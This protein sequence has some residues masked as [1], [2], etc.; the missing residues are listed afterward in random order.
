MAS[1]GENRP[2]TLPTSTGTGAS[3]PVSVLEF[4]ARGDGEA[5]DTAAI[6]Y[7]LDSGAKKVI[8]PQGTYLLTNCIEPHSGQEIEIIGTLKVADAIVRTVRADVAAGQDQIGLDDTRGLYPGQWVTLADANLRLQSGGTNQTRRTWAEC[9][10]IR[11]VRG[12]SVVLDGTLSESYSLA[13]GATLATQ[14]SALLIEGASGVHVH[15]SGTIDGNKGGQFDVAPCRTGLSGEEVRAGCGI[16]VSEPA[17][18][19]VI[20][21]LTVRDAVL[22]NISLNRASFCTV[23]NTTCTGAH[24]KNILLLYCFDCRIVGNTTRD[25]D[26]ED[27]IILYTGSHRCLVQQNICTGNPR[28]GIHVGARQTCINTAHNI[29]RDNSI[30]ISLIG[31]ICCSTGD[32]SIG[33]NGKQK[34]R[35]AAVVLAGT[36]N[37]M[38]NLTAIGNTV[39]Q[40][41]VSVS[42]TDVAIL[43]GIVG[44]VRSGDTDGVGIDI[45]PTMG[46]LKALR[47][48]TRVR[49]RDVFLNDCKT[50]LRVEGQAEDIH[51]VDNGFQGND[52]DLSIAAEARANVRVE[53]GH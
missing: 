3:G 42:G 32:T 10:R 39:G 27:G 5:D 43:G 22:H 12:N 8:I 46:R 29:C 13:A 4:G 30:N 41:N 44:G 19:I 14:P 23:S 21:G 2:D 28:Y 24:D 49:I 52:S 6:Q 20:E 38:M 25:S 17:R 35:P 16:A 7:A 40:S 26:F 51:L 53:P 36:G 9:T 47:V 11:E 45:S 18:D 33:G 31:D 1:A 34:A 50:A 37:T 48:P 15:G